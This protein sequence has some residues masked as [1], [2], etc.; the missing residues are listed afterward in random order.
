MI[1]TNKQMN[2]H[3]QDLN[4]KIRGTLLLE[5]YIRIMSL[6]IKVDL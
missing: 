5:S 2:T 4:I 6:K 3:F 1:Q